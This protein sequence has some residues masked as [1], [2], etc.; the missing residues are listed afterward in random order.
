MSLPRWSEIEADP[1]FQA[2][3]E[4]EKKDFF[5]NWGRAATKKAMDIGDYRNPEFNSAFTENYN[6]IASRYGDPISYDS[7]Q[8]IYDSL[9]KKEDEYGILRQAADIPIGLG[10]GA[11]Q[12]VRMF[13]DILGADNPASQTIRGVEGYLGNL[14]SAQAKDDQA[15]I[16]R[17]FK[18]AEDKGVL[19]QV[20][21]GI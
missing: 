14:M 7:V 12:G 5:R 21:A 20:K 6:K 4:D 8:S 19:E 16:A 17:I 13:T 9:Q 15:E 18:D 2:F 11:L 10:K 3:D 1:K